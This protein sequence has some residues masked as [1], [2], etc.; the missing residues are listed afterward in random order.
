VFGRPINC[1]VADAGRRSPDPYPWPY[2]HP[3]PYPTRVRVRSDRCA[4]SV[5]P[6]APSGPLA[7]ARLVVS[8][9]PH[10]SAVFRDFLL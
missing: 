1:R 9:T 8:H 10:G 5:S 2:P 3:H 7:R 4:V 6:A